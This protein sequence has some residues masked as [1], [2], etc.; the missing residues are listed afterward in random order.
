MNRKY[1]RWDM[2]VQRD[3]LVPVDRLVMEFGLKPS[4]ETTPQGDPVA[5]WNSAE[6]GVLDIKVRPDWRPF[7]QISI[8]VH[9]PERTAGGHLGMSVQMATH[10]PGIQDPDRFF[11]GYPLG[12]A[13]R[14]PR[15]GWQVLPFPYE[16]FLIYGIPAGWHA[17]DTLAMSLGG[18]KSVLIGDVALEQRSRAPGPRMTDEGLFALLDL[19]RPALKRLRGPAGRG[20]YVEARKRLAAHL[21]RRKRPRHIY[22]RRPQGAVDLK[23]ADAVLR[24]F[25][26][27]VDLGADIDWR[28]NPIGYLEWMHAFNRHGFMR[29][30]LNAWLATGAEKYAAELDYLLSTWMGANPVPQDNNGGGDPAWETLSTAVR[31]YGTW[32]DVLFGTL[33]SKA[34][35]DDTRVD[36]L[37][38]MYAHAEHL[39]EHSVL[40]GNNWTVVESQ[41]IATLGMVF[42]E[43]RRA[44]RWQR[45]GM[46]RLT[47]EMKRQVYPDGAQWELSAGYHAMSGQGFAGP[48]EIARLNGIDVPAAYEKR[49][50]GM[51]DYS[52]K[53]SRPNGSLPSHNDSGGVGAGGNARWWV[54]VGARLFRDPHMKWY[55]TEGKAGRAPRFTS[56]AFE[57]AGLLVMRSGWSARDNYL[58]FDA[59]PYGAAHQHED[60]LGIEV[61]ALGTLFLV[62]PGIAGYMLEDWTHYARSTFAHNT[63]I[64]DGR[65]QD[66]RG[67]QSREQHVRSVRGENLW[68]TG[69]VLDFARSAY[70]A[71]YA[72]LDAK[73]VHTRSVLF[74]RPDYWIVFDEITGSGT[75]TAEALFQFMPMRVQSDPDSNRVR[76]NRLGRANLEIVPLPG[77]EDASVEIVCGRQSPVQGWITDGENLPAPCAVYRKRGKLPMRMAWALCPFDSANSAGVS[78]EPVACAKDASAFRL[79]WLDGASDVVFHRLHGRGRARFGKFSTDGTAC[80]IRLGPDGSLRAAAA[81]GASVLARSGKSILAGR[82]KQPLLESQ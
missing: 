26:A 61:S 74:V 23:A 25:I 36:M 33:E 13:R 82:K 68:A 12:G 45:E 66:R 51:F 65:P 34:F 75:H 44:A 14:T 71:G 80:L 6:C 11:T 5:V 63:V 53:L 42:P 55:A 69:S 76:T 50:R 54:S 16:N 10:T 4:R 17:V 62:D 8:P 79:T 19:N 3:I 73:I 58:L 2:V 18:V 22:P 52:W 49:L 32:L 38:S 77:A 57:D 9:V 24:H 64:V 30:L 29:T 47:G 20:D 48:L 37:K 27:G 41:A 78:V 46:R 21:K 15:C 39:M 7:D 28:A 31:I 67:R 1:F 60:K 59:G 72:G 35:R 70:A 81:V 40:W 43:F 56:H